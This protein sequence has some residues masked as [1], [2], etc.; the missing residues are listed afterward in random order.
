MKLAQDL[1]AVRALHL[2]LPFENFRYLDLI[3]KR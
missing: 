1:F 2:A 3:T